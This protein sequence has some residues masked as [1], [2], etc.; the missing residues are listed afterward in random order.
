MEHKSNYES[1]RIKQENRPFSLEV[2]VERVFLGG[3][4]SSPGPL[5]RRYPPP[6]LREHLPGG[7]RKAPKISK[8]GIL[9]SKC[10]TSTCE[11]KH[12]SREIPKPK[13]VSCHSGG[14]ELL[15]R[16]IT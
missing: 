7:L 4:R 12:V 1:T 16:G 14:D 11:A 8:A 10:E 2:Q 13:H 3:S 5:G 6:K 9:Q 15:G